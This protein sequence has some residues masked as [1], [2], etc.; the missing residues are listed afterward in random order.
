MKR[1]P[2]VAGYFY[3]ENPRELK[4]HLSTLIKFKKNKIKAKGIIVPHAGYMYSGWVAGKVY[5]SILPPDTAMII[6]TNHTGLGERISIFP[7]ESFITPLGETLID[8]ELTEDLVKLVPIIAKDVMAHLHEHSIEV[9]VP[10]LQYINPEVKIVSLCLGRL[11]LEEVIELGRG[12]SEVIKRYPD[13]YVLIIGSSDFSHYVPH[14]VAKEKDMMA[15]KEILK[16]SEESFLKVI[17]EERVSACGYIP[18]AV[19]INAC[20]NLGANKAELIDYMTSGDVIKD[21]SSVVGYAG[22]I[23]Y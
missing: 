14:E 2:A 7:G 10:F 11:K 12:I 6:G 1:E 5:G 16:L 23:I 20:K 17:F 13:K 19:T 9:Q 21:Y 8:K 15:I 18:I 3:S 4:F 22:I